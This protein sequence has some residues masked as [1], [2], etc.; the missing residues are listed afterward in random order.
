MSNTKVRIEIEYGITDAGTLRATNEDA[1]LLAPAKNLYIVADG[2]GGHNA[3]EVASRE[4]VAAVD[5]Y[6]TPALRTAIAGQ[7]DRIAATLCQALHLANEHILALAS[8]NPAYAGMGCTVA[9]VL[10]DRDTLHVCNVGDARTYVSSID[11]IEQLSTDHSTTM[12]LVQ[13]GWM[14]LAE[15]RA[16]PLRAEVTQAVGMRDSMQP[17]YRSHVLKNQDRVV[18]CSDGLWDMLS[19]EQ[20]QQVVRQP[21]SARELCEALVE[22]ANAAGGY[23]NI[24]VIVLTDPLADGADGEG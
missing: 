16:S 12:L 14:T 17:A 22:L 9:V 8:S 4:A 18:I 15:A 23:D 2:M 24:T 21:R 19:D 1:F 11:G 6:L 5:A 7:A 13:A 3:G 20:I 10:V